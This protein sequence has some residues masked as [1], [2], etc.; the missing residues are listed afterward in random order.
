VDPHSDLADDILSLRAKRELLDSDYHVDFSRTDA[1][2][3][4]RILQQPYVRDPQHIAKNI[5][6]ALQ[7]S[8]PALTD[9]AALHFDY[10]LLSGTMARIADQVSREDAVWLA[11]QS[12]RFGPH[13]EKPVVTS[14]GDNKKTR[15]NHTLLT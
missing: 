8:W 11:P 9:G 13:I 12:A 7:H 1:Y 3:P 6:A 4:F 15:P 2:I 5:V 10:L 14:V